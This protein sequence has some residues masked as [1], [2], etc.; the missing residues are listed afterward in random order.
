METPPSIENSTA[1][2]A[3]DIITTPRNPNDSWEDASSLNPGEKES[4]SEI[5]EEDEDEVRSILQVISWIVLPSFTPEAPN[6]LLNVLMAFDLDF[7]ILVGLKIDEAKLTS[8]TADHGTTCSIIGLLESLK[9]IAM[10]RYVLGNLFRCKEVKKGSI[11]LWK[12]TEVANEQDEHDWDKLK[13]L[14]SF[15]LKQVL[16]EYPEAKMTT[17]EQNASLRGTYPELVKSYMVLGTMHPRNGF[18]YP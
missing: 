11:G 17:E 12:T 16:S 3:A 9:K 18:G 14:L 10:V 4:K 13:S 1:N 8:M 2:D 6:A 5:V 15:K 7:E